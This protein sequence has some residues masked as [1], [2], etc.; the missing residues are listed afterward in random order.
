VWL[1]SERVGMD[2]RHYIDEG[3]I[4]HEQ[5]VGGFTSVA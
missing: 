4:P 3:E 2:H 5:R 1:I